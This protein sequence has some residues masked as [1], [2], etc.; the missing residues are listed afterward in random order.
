ME[1]LKLVPQLFYDLIARVLPGSVAIIILATATDLKLGKL[2]TDFWDGAPAIQQSALFLG[3][4]FFVA[5]YVVGQIISPISDFI[6]NKIVKRLFPAYFLALKNAL[7]SSSEYSPTVRGFLLKELG[8]EKEK[9]TTQMTTGQSSKA[10]F[11]WYDW[12][13]ANAPDSGAR[14][15]KIRAEYRMH[16]QNT[17]AFLIALAVHLALGYIRQSNI[18]PALIIVLTVA[19]LTS[20]WAT[21]RTYR[22]FRWAVVQQFY[23]VKAS[24]VNAK[25]DAP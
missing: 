15:A 2:T 12:L 25:R 21:A 16:S 4:S 19:G 13:R 11:V 9:E 8:Y 18:N 22:T 6:E 20:L 14:A 3:F 24:G 23:A 17:V 7:S 1:A 10:V 5:A